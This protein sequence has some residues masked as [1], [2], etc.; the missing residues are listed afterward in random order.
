MTVYQIAKFGVSCNKLLPVR[1]TYILKIFLALTSSQ[2]MVT[3]PYFWVVLMV[4]VVRSNSARDIWKI[5]DYCASNTL[6]ILSDQPQYNAPEDILRGNAELPEDKHGV[7]SWSVACILYELNTGQPAFPDLS[8]L[9]D[10]YYK[11]DPAP[12]ISEQSN[13]RLSATPRTLEEEEKTHLSTMWKSV[14]GFADIDMYLIGEKSTVEAFDCRLFQIN[15]MVSRSLSRTCKERPTLKQIEI[16]SSANVVRSKLED[17]EVAFCG[18]TPAKF[19]VIW[20]LPFS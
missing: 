5:T 18:S 16:H 10:Y 13:G 20:S 6:I 4:I 12:Q 17:D 7:G 19:R 1:S 8:S 2:T 9:M 3:T 15:S 11:S 14:H